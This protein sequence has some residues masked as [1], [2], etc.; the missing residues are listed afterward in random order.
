MTPKAASPRLNLNHPFWPRLGTWL[1]GIALPLIALM[2][3]A[4]LFQGCESAESY[5]SETGVEPSEGGGGNNGGDND[6]TDPD[7]DDGSVDGYRNLAITP[8]ASTLTPTGGSNTSQI[9]FVSLSISPLSGYTYRWTLS[10]ASLGTLSQKTGASV[11]YTASPTSYPASGSVLQT[12][13]VTGTR[14]GADVRYRGTAT[15]THQAP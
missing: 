14:S 13:T 4:A 9:Q 7:N 12:I 10:D 5:A 15:V 11:Q 2:A 6:G 1:T 8:P 3:L